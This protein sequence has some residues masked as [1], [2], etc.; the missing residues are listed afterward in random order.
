MTGT[1]KA[2]M[3]A[4][5]EVEQPASFGVMEDGHSDLESVQ[6][7]NTERRSVTSNAESGFDIVSRKD[8]S[9]IRM[10]RFMVAGMLAMT[11]AVTV[12]A[13]YFLAREENRNFETAV[14]KRLCHSCFPGR[15]L[16]W[17][18]FVRVS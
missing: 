6:E 1:S 10:F 3:L 11:A 14:R 18:S 4:T 2:G 7:N 17:Q 5:A 8:A 16:T 9:R 15:I 13:F 12:T